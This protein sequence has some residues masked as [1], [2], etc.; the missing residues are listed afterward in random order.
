MKCSVCGKEMV[1]TKEDYSYRE[2]E[3]P[4]VILGNIEVRR[5]SEGHV[6]AVIPRLAALHNE[7][8]L[9][10]ANQP[11]RLSPAEFRFLRKHMGYASKV[12]ARALG[13]APETLSRWEKGREDHSQAAELAIREMIKAGRTAEDYRELEPQKPAPIRMKLGNASQS[14]STWELQPA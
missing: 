8:A 13:V 4:N 5:C 6:Q 1:V 11:T 2:I 12:F 7:L 14:P 3:V 9:V 10:M